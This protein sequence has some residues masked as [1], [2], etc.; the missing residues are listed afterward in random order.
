M[1]S[2]FCNEETSVSYGGIG[3]A[4]THPNWYISIYTALALR[5]LCEAY[6]Y[7][8]DEHLKKML[9]TSAEHLLRYTQNDYFC[10]A[11]QESVQ[12]PYPYWIAGGGMILKGINDVERVLGITFDV[13]AKVEKILSHQLK[14]GGVSSFLKYNS[15]DNHRRKNHPDARVWEEIAPGPPWNAHLFEYLTRFA[16]K[17][18]DNCKPANKA[19]LSVR[20]RYIY[21]ENNKAFFVSS[22][23]PLFSCA[24]VVINKR[25]N[26][27]IIG[28]SLRHTYS[29]IIRKIRKIS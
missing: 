26:K 23:F 1:T 25:R 29:K 16:T 13:D 2:L 10:H 15:R 8:Q 11:I 27:S 9:I 7:K 18:I 4:N 19:S 20:L 14:C 3:Y 6:K 21:F 5:G 22:V 17:D 12:T 24:L 28:F